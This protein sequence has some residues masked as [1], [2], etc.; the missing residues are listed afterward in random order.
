MKQYGKLP[1]YK[2]DVEIM[3]ISSI[4]KQLKNE[5]KQ[6]WLSIGCTDNSYYGA[7]FT[8][9]EWEEFKNQKKSNNVGILNVM[10]CYE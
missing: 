6:C 5:K 2:T 3:Q 7:F 1:L 8:V 4:I 9:E 10:V